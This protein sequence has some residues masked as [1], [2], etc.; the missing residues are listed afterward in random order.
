MQEV[1]RAAAEADMPKVEVKNV[2]VDCSTMGYLDTMGV[3][4]MKTVS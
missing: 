4:A 3:G 1:D 2:I